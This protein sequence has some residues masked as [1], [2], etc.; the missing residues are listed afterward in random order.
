MLC[1]KLFSYFKYLLAT[2]LL[3]GCISVGNNFPS[4]TKWLVKDQTSQKDVLMIL[5]R[6]YKTGVS[7]GTST[8]TYAYYDYK[9]W[10]KP[11]QKEL[12]IY[13]KGDKKI[14]SFH[15]YSSFPKDVK[16]FAKVSPKNKET[17]DT[18]VKR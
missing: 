6:P 9:V 10:Q 1:K 2:G 7:K 13:W 5:G 15:F 14:Q 18:N 8:W 11:A 17:V 4:Q 3:T 12:K 16:N